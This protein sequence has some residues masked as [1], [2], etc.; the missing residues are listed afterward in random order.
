MEFNT[1]KALEKGV[2]IWYFREYLKPLVKVERVERGQE[3]DNFE[4]IVKNTVDFEVKITLRPH[5]YIYKTDRYYARGSC[6]ATTNIYTQS[7]SIKDS[8][9]EESKAQTQELRS[10]EP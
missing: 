5:S 4:E 6:L 2:M 10:Q 9:S 8:G 7:S 3:F 1:D